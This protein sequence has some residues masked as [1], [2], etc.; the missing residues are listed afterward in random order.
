MRDW[1]IIRIVL[2]TCAAGASLAACNAQPPIDAAGAMPT[3]GFHRSGN[4]P[5][6]EPAERNYS[7]LLSFDVTDGAQPNGG[8]LNVGGTLYG[9]TYGGGGGENCPVGDGCGTVFSLTASGSESVLYEFLSPPD[10]AGP[11][12]SLT[13]VNGTLYGTTGSGGSCE[14]DDGCGTVF[15]VTTAGV[16]NVLYR[17]AGG[18]DGSSPEPGLVEV[19]GL[20]YGTTPTGGNGC[21]TVYSV[22]MATGDKEVLH[23]FA[24]GSDGCM[25]GGGL[26]LVNGKLYGTT[27]SGGS[28]QHGTVFSVTLAGKERVLYSFADP[29]DGADPRG[30]L[31]DLDGTLYG[32]TSSGGKP[33]PCA[34]RCG[35]VY[36]VTTS[37]AEQILHRFGGDHRDGG[38]PDGP[39][40]NIGDTLYGTTYYWG[41]YKRGTVFSITTAGKERVLYNFTRV[42]HDGGALS[43]D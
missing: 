39:L 28:H 4:A 14:G 13:D 42:N 18:K 7:V 1:D 33:A 15:S 11:G 6:A 20:L 23:N 27:Q 5:Y 24:I 29:P 35:T 22:S 43:G 26:T 41:K 31:I 19:N 10:G 30:G 16:E 8:L 40:V 17:F 34:H 25:P 3:A 32:T 37:G 2:A 9:T 36:S 12:G 21:G 38:D